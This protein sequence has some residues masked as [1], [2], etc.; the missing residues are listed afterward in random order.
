MGAGLLLREVVLVL[1][2]IM[3]APCINK[4]PRMLLVRDETWEL[5]PAGKKLCAYS[6]N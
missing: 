5:G 4:Y 3:L 6:G 2:P 1:K